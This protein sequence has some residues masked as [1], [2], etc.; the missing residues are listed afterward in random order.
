MISPDTIGFKIKQEISLIDVTDCKYDETDTA[1]CDNVK[2]CLTLTIHSFSRNI[3][4][5][6]I[7]LF[8]L[9]ALV[10]LLSILLLN[11]D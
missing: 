3:I 11:F 7:I 8:Y 10:Y 2:C 1:Y 4:Y 6:M 5:K 9:N